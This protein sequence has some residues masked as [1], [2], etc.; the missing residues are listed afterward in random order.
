MLNF[1]EGC[2]IGFCLISDYSDHPQPPVFR[3]APRGWPSSVA[4]TGGQVRE[5]IRQQAGGGHTAGTK[6]SDSLAKR[7]I[8]LFA[9]T[10]ETLQSFIRK[11]WKNSS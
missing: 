10:E 8:F 1:L 4:V 7:S 11:R 2:V 3:A 5:Q 9:R 6:A